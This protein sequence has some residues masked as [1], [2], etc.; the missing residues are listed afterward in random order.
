MQLTHL[1]KDRINKTGLQQLLTISGAILIL[2]G[3]ITIIGWITSSRILINIMPRYVPMAFTNSIFFVLFGLVFVSGEWKIKRQYYRI[4]TLAVI[5]IC[6][7]YSVLQFAGYFVKADLN[8]EYTLLPVREKLGN[9]P[10]GHMSPYSGLLFFISGTAIILKVLIRQRAIIKNIVGGLGIIVAF[11]GFVAGLG[12]LFGTPFLYSGNAIPLSLRTTI[13][14][15][16]QGLGILFMAGKNSIFL[17]Q[18]IGPTPDARLLR[19]LVPIIIAVFLLEGVLDVIFT[20]YY[21]INEALLLASL[22]IFSVILCVI[23]IVNISKVIFQSANRSEKERLRAIEE[24]RKVNALHTLIL[25]NSTMGICMVRNDQFQWNNSRFNEIF[26]LPLNDLKGSSTSII[27]KP[28]EVFGNRISYADIMKDGKSVDKTIQFPRSNGDLFWCRFIGTPLDL[29]DTN[30]GSIWMVEDVTERRQTREKLL[31]LSHTLES[32]AECVSITD[33]SDRIIFVNKAF[34]KTYGYSQEELIGKNISIV[35]SSNNDQELIGKILPATLDGGWKGEIINR[36][37]DGTEFPV[38]MASSKV[39][40]KS[41]EVVALVGVASD[42]TERIKLDRQLKKY[43]Q[44]L[45]VS[46][47]AKDKLFSIISHDLISPFNSMLGF[48]NL[49]SEQYDDMSE[50]D[51]K[52]FILDLKKSSENTF[53]LLQNLLTWSRT[54]TGG[55]KVNPINFDL[56]AVVDLQLEVLKNAAASK[57]INLANLIL[58]GIKVYADKDMVKTILINLINNA[59]KF[60]RP[61]GIITI[62]S[63]IENSVA[64]I[65]VEDNGVG[66]E[67]SVL[68]NM[69]KPDKSQSTLGTSREKGTGLGLL[70]CKEFAERNNG[71]IWV[72]SEPGKGS[73][74]IFTLPVYSNDVR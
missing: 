29:A 15:I 34:Q 22:T 69:F 33:T 46:N 36:R 5:G 53:V 2:T 35:S 65:T 12:Y 68:E 67:S 14:F 41:G 63:V 9:F 23:V 7:L 37:K 56:S 13:L 3:L 1:K 54:Q 39:V 44:E 47:D 57:D 11:A 10:V 17:Q 64:E 8:F 38:Y 40:D 19:I 32:L 30:E 6:S 31:L 62:N 74:F 60:T 70:I 59:I 55:I 42:I 28:D 21:K 20:H 4:T 27:P 51:R 25:E 24:L 61:G 52:S 49:I 71:K 45:K 26:E 18:F 73:K 58:H 48:F 43:S 72:K 66:I 16:F 50:D